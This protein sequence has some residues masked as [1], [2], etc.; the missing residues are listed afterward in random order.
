MRSYFR[1]FCHPK[2]YVRTLYHSRSIFSTSI[3]RLWLYTNCREALFRKPWSLTW[4]STLGGIKL[5]KTNSAHVGLYQEHH[6]SVAHAVSVLAHFPTHPPCPF[7]ICTALPFLLQLKYPIVTTF[8]VLTFCYYWPRRMAELF[9]YSLRTNLARQR[10]GCTREHS[11]SVSF[12]F[13]YH[14]AATAHPIH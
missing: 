10:P 5:V 9:A 4:I 6:L 11:G 8:P 2:P 13:L 12:P 14:L 7:R 3:N 1:I